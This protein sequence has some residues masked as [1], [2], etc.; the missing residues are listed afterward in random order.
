LDFAL[1]EQHRLLQA[2]VREFCE[3]EVRPH[4]RKW[5]EE[6]RFPHEIVPKL[7]AL[8]LLGI[9]IPEEYGGAGMDTLAYA[10]AVEECAALAPATS[11]ISAARPRSSAT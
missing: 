2:T 9:R 5:D 10:I 8:G 7:A 3:R 1:P 4:A 11:S 6:E